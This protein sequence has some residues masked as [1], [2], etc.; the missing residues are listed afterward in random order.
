MTKPV[1]RCSSLDREILCPWSRPASLLV[2]ERESESPY[3]GI[4]GHWKIAS[5]LVTEMRAAE[6][7][8]GLPPPEVPE[9][10]TWNN[11]SDWLVNYCFREAK[12]LVPADWSLEVEVPLA[13]EFARFILSGHTDLV[14]VNADATHAIG[15]DWK[16]G[17]LAVD[18]AE[19]NRQ[20]LGYIVLLLR[21][22]PTLKR[23]DFYVVQPRNHEDDGDQR[24]TSVTVLNDE[25]EACVASL[26]AEINQSLDNEDQIESGRSQC[27]Y[28]PVG[29][30]CPAIQAEVK[31]MKLKANP[32]SLARLR[33]TPDDQLLAE[34]IEGFKVVE[35]AVSTAKEIIHERLA[36]VKCIVAPSG[37]RITS[38]T[39]GGS[40][41]PNN[42]PAILNGLLAIAPAHKVA[43]VVNY[44]TTRI[45]DLIAEE[46]DVPKTGKAAVT[47]QSEFDRRFRPH[48]DQGTKKTLIF[49]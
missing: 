22:Y 34:V 13:Y 11:D 44:S 21:A 8:G 20:V 30:Q 31:N 18:P 6:P 14:A 28:C 41:T 32:L 4:M 7:V 40:Y 5:R 16:H 48:L 12:N 37:T 19:F 46:M 17:Y 2:S 42:A 23:V 49:S 9:S 45:K 27:K 36:I 15:W 35:G 25:C 38:K 39:S 1:I 3:E 33:A 47:A 43:A 10:Y 24:V 26:E 29:I